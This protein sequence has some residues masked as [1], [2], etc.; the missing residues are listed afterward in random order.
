MRIR[1]KLLSV[2]AVSVIVPVLIVSLFAIYQTR[3]IALLSFEQSSRKEIQQVDNA[4][5]I[6]FTGIADNVSFLADHPLAKD[7]GFNLSVFVDGPGSF[8]TH[9]NV[10]G[11]EAELYKLYELF[12]ESHPGLAYVYTGRE[13]GG[14][15]SWP[16]VLLTDPYDPRS[17]P[18][19]KAAMSS[20][21]K[22]IR[23]NAYYWAGDDATYVGTSK[24]ISND[25]GQIIGVQ[26]MD[27]SVNSL[28]EIVKNI[29]IGE[30]G[31]IVL[32]ED[33]GT[34]LVDPLLPDNNFKKIGELNTELYSNLAQGASGL[35][36][37]ERDGKAYL[38]EIV[39][40]EKMGWTF[41]ALVPASEV[42]GAAN[43]IAWLS[44]FRFSRRLP[45]YWSGGC[46]TDFA[47]YRPCCQC[48]RR[49]CPR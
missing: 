44:A 29:K 30:E 15:L 14:Y 46:P 49:D 10:G 2:I 36:T 26:S 39:K 32:I 4:F 31:H 7:D 12:G 37:I 24:T 22:I 43:Q 3:Q 9:L 8:K 19:Y 25:R 16:D 20:P 13:D 33:N 48:A 23:T 41:V 17:R 11:K 42:Y 18:W 21:G 47:P 27:V 38:A 1:T 34:V 45:V 35:L 40:S 6:F 5:D 28:T